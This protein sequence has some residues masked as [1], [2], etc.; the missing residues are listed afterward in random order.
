LFDDIVEADGVVADS[1]GVFA[2]GWNCYQHAGRCGGKAGIPFVLK[3]RSQI[4][5]RRAC[6]WSSRVVCSEN[7]G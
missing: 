2:E 6:S 7:R 4:L 1:G 5:R 3:A